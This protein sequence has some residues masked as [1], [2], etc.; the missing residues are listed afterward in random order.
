MDT[1]PLY[2]DIISALYLCL[3]LIKD[4]DPEAKGYDDLIK[5]SAYLL[6]AKKRQFGI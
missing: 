5:I 2:T 1:D 3:D 6:D 4:T